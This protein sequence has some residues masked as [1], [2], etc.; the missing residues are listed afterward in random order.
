[1]RQM[2]SSTL[3]TRF[4]RDSSVWLLAS[5]TGLAAIH[6]SL[7]S[8]ANDGSLLSSSIV[9]WIAI[10]SMLWSKKKKLSFKS[11]FFGGGLGILILSL[12][13]VKSSFMQGYDP[14]LRILPLF[15]MIGL[16]L[17]ASGVTGLGQ[18]WKE[19]S[20]LSFLTPPPSVLEQVINTSPVTAKFSTALL[21]YAGFPVTRENQ[22]ILIPN[23][24]VEVYSGCSGVDTML[25]L[26]GLS[27]VF[28]ALFP[29]SK[30]QK[31]V[32][33]LLAIGIAFVVNGVRVSLMAALSEPTNKAMFEYWHKGDGSL[34]F[35]MISVVLLA[36][37]CYFI[38]MPERPVAYAPPLNEAVEDP[39]LADSSPYTEV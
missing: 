10:A 9:Y 15:S 25:H 35:S 14:F 37:Y 5:F 26:L 33:P 27:A 24:G 18:F 36:T 11:S 1:N 29:T 6:L 8:K 38:S 3:P 17:L 20:I 19:L 22:F 31:L 39:N 12:V 32:L 13:L 28:V 23:G 34:L 4:F 7:A 30:L 21:W 16:G 2:S